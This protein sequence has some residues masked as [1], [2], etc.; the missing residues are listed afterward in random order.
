M[1]KTKAKDVYIMSE[2]TKGV[3]VVTVLSSLSVENRV[4][5]YVEAEV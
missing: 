1:Y 5:V 2:V 3:C 4:T